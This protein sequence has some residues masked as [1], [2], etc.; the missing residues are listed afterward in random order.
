MSPSKRKF[1][2]GIMRSTGIKRYI[3]PISGC[4]IW[5]TNR[6]CRIP[7]DLYPCKVEESMTMKKVGDQTIGVIRRRRIDKEGNVSRFQEYHTS[8]EEEEELSEHPPYNKYGFVDHPQ[9]QMEDQRNKFAPYPL[10]PQEGNMNG[11]LIDD[12]NDSDLES[13]TSNQPMSLTMEDIGFVACGPRDFDRTGG[14]VALTRWIEKME[15]VIDSSGCLANQRVK[16]AAS[17][18]IGKALTWWNTQ[19]QARGR[20]AANAMAWNDFKALLTMEFCPS[21]EIEKLEGEFWNHSMAKRVTRYI[22]GLLSQIRR[23]LRATQPATIQVVILTAGILTDEVVR[24]G[25]LAKAGEKRKER[26]EASKSESVEKD[27]KK[28][29]GGRG[30]VAAVPPRRENR[31]FPKCV[32][33]KGFHA[34]KTMHSVL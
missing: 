3:D 5:R 25:T 2:W 26:N 17:S 16:Y 28:A 20:D 21:N 11:W 22:N 4:K 30:F 14:A 34:E 15:S 1:R 7:I 19:F 10:P 12:V 32:R 9:L 6:K 23:M 27:E 8:D 24:S 29:K 13:T 33:C 31:N 18:F